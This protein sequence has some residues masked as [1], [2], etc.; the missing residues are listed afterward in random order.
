VTLKVSD[1]DAF[2]T[3]AEVK[4]AVQEGI[5]TSVE[6]ATDKVVI[7]SITQVVRRLS[8][9]ERRLAVA[10]SVKAKY[11]IT[12]DAK[13]IDP[14]AAMAALAAK[15]AASTNAALKK[16][17]KGS[18]VTAPATAS[19]P[20][21]KVAPKPVA[22]TTKPATTTGPEFYTEVKFDVV[23]EVDDTDVFLTSTDV[24][25]SL[26]AA[27]A[28]LLELP[29]K[30]VTVDSIALV[31]ATGRRLKGAQG[32]VK[33]AVTAKDPNNK[34]TP[35]KAKGIAPKLPAAAN[36]LL[37]KGKV[38]KATI[39]IAPVAVKKPTKK[40]D[41]CKVQIVVPPVVVAP[42]SP[43]A[44]V[45]VAPAPVAPV[46][47][48]APVVKYSQ[49]QPIAD[50]V[51][52]NPWF[53]GLAGLMVPFLLGMMVMAVRSFRQRGARNTRV[54]VYSQLDEVNALANPVE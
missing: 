40:P 39:P 32:K 36:K 11:K 13:K 17:G 44:P 42:V 38:G 33:P 50:A 35:A 1:V 16:A 12:D 43:C 30:D 7:E 14:A 26:Q 23:L 49:Q 4:A 19:L 52:A 24:V 22:T 9:E 46:N 48:C 25:T 41:P 20:V 54:G 31:T 3:S 53:A 2:T 51:A 34:L 37:P 5:A 21:K 10:G 45:V 27:I 6:V 18:S 29:E 8:G 47:P 15:V 28:S